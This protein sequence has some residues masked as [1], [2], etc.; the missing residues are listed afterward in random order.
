MQKEIEQRL[1]RLDQY[2][3][4]LMGMI[5]VVGGALGLTVALATHFL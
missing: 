5:I 3:S 2:K 1:D 4:K